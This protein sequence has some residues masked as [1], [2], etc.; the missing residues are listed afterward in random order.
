MIAQA[1]LADA[2]A[3]VPAGEDDLAAGSPVSYLSL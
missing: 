1:A 3:L 2:L